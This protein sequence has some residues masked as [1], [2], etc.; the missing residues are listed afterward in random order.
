MEVVLGEFEGN[1]VL[2]M[3]EEQGWTSILVQ[4]GLVNL[5]V[6]KEFYANL[7]YNRSS[8]FEFTTWVRGKRIVITPDVWSTFLEIGRPQNPVYPLE[9]LGDDVPNIHFNIVAE[10]LTGGPYEWPSG[11]LPH[12]L[13][14]ADLRLLNLIVCY[15]IC[16]RII[17]V[18]IF[19]DCN[20]FIS[21]L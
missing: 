15:N 9:L 1:P 16:K 2:R 7:D 18:V 19:L 4:S 14:S 13:L 6:V 5:S 21:C 10:F 8:V 11:C 3:I 20:V 17:C 12:S